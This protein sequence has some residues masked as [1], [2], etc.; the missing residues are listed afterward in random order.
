MK[1]PLLATAT[2]EGFTAMVPRPSVGQMTVTGADMTSRVAGGL[3]WNRSV[4]VELVKAR[5]IQAG[6]PGRRA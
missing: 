1:V 6:W 4:A 3:L 5:R 2:V